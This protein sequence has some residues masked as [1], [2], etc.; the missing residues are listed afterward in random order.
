MFL[1]ILCSCGPSTDG[2]S[3]RVTNKDPI[4]KLEMVLSAAGVESDDFPAI[5][6]FIDFARDSSY[7]AKSYDNPAFPGSIYS[8]S[9]NEIH[10]VRDLLQAADLTRLKKNYT[11][12][13]TDQPTSTTSVYIHGQKLIFK[14]YGLQGEYPLQNLYKIVYKF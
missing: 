3:K 6:V 8:L 1:L 14:D 13:A 2:R 12:P 9:Y 5:T 7:C 11:V 10:Q 4:T